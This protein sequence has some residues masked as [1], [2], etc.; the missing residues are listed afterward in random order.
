M[1]IYITG[2]S[3]AGF[4][5]PWYALLPCFI[6]SLPCLRIAEHILKEQK[7]NS[8][9]AND[10]KTSIPFVTLPPSLPPLPCR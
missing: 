5:I 6:T 1:P 10:R 3:Y 7:E 8:Y 2:E 4:Y 9:R